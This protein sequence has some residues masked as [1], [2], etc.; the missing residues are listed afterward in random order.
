MA[1]DGVIHVAR[2]KQDLQV[3]TQPCQLFRQRPA[4][5]FWHDQIGHEQVDGPRITPGDIEGFFSIAGFENRVAFALQGQPRQHADSLFVLGDQHRL[6]AAGSLARS[7]RSI[8]GRIGHRL[9][10]K[11][12]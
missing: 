7:W 4:A 9:A 8:L 3:G 6:A 5:Q 1:N 2:D 12:S 11:K 10:A